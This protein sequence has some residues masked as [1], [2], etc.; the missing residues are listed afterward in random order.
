MK[1]IED[2]IPR[3]HAACIVR[4][5]EISKL[6]SKTGKSMRAENLVGI[7]QAFST[8]KAGFIAVPT[9]KKI[10]DRRAF[11]SGAGSC[12]DFATLLAPR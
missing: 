4:A 6:I 11:F 5:A 9:G 2:P 7:E 1:E 8:L 12:C 3:E 10:K